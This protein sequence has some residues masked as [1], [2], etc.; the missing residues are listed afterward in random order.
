MRQRHVA[1]FPNFHLKQSG[2]YSY[3]L[4]KQIT[5][6]PVGTHFNDAELKQKLDG[7]K[8]GAVDALFENEEVLGKLNLKE[9]QRET[10]IEKNLG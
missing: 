4:M 8:T 6:F 10:L 1:L 9:A 5:K 7:L 2:R 3:Y